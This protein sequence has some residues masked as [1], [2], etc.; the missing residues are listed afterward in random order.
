MMSEIM[1]CLGGKVIPLGSFPLFLVLMVQEI[2]LLIFVQAPFQSWSECI[3]QP[4][5]GTD[6]GTT[7]TLVPDPAL[8]S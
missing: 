2:M 8:P 6:G 4:L 5:V 3:P 1:T 7:T